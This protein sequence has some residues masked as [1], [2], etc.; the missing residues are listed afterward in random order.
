MIGDCDALPSTYYEK[1]DRKLRFCQTK[2]A[3]L[4]YRQNLRV[5]KISRESGTVV[6][7]F[8]QVRSL[9]STVLGHGVQQYIHM[10]GD[11][12]NTL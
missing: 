1:D 7:F 5:S 11:R 3:N 9:V 8:I 10:E 6:E 4:G 2:G 12:G